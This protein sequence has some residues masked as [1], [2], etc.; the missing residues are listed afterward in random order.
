MSGCSFGAPQHEG[1]A[2]DHF[3]GQRFKNLKTM[4]RPGVGWVLHWQFTRSRGGWPAHAPDSEPGPKPPN[5]VADGALRVTLV[6]H[7]TVLIQMDGVNILTDPVYS[8]TVGPL[9]GVGSTRVRPPAIRWEDLPPI[10]L[11]IVSHN[12]YDHMDAPTLKRL[13]QEHKPLILAGLGSK[14]LLAEK[15]ITGAADLDW[16]QSRKL[17]GL[18][19]TA[20]PAQHFSQRGLDDQDHT[21]WCSFVVE[22]PSG[23]I[24]FAGDT[25]W[26]P[27]FGQ[28]AKRF[29]DFRLGILPI[30]AYL[31][32]WFMKYVH[33]TPDEAIRAHLVLKAATSIGMH[34]DTFHLADESYGQAERDLRMAR[35]RRGVSPAEFPVL[36]WGIG[37]LIP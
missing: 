15:G 30:G 24:Y 11:V 3:D 18:T 9:P 32:R 20:A 12:H 25:A 16:W 1:D 26:G 10:H 21:L 4:N 34:H 35:T 28:I 19:V 5:R 31:P 2:S 7:A 37:R 8:D 22:G 6:G 27:H 36:D 13:A 14:A 17:K 23:R 29:G 33:I